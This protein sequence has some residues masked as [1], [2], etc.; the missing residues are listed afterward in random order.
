MATITPLRP[1][2]P[3]KT[4]RRDNV[5]YTIHKVPNRIYA[6]PSRETNLFTCVVSF[7]NME[8]AYII[9]NLIEEHKKR[10]KNWPDFMSDDPIMLPKPDKF[11]NLSELSVIKW[12]VDDL[13]YYCVSNVLD[14]IT[15]SRVTETDQGYNVKGESLHFEAPQEFYQERFTELY[16]L[17]VQE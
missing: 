13:K 5:L 4:G 6:V 14:L 17:T 3:L 16:S 7:K 15:L 8:H 1:T 10:T 11:T 9:A 2:R 12:D